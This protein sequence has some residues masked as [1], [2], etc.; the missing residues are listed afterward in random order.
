MQ[1]MFSF[2]LLSVILMLLTLNKIKLNPNK[3]QRMVFSRKQSVSNV[4]YDDKSLAMSR[5]SI[6]NLEVIL[7]CNLSLEEQI[8]STV[9]KCFFSF[10]QHW[11]NS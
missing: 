9:K 5:N 3:T 8:M 1:M 6:K 10:S 4:L 7:D 2:V 11:T